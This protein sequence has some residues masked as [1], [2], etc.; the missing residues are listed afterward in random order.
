[1][2]IKNFV[3]IGV[4]SIDPFEKETVK[5]FGIQA[6]GMREI[7][8]YGIEKVMEMALEKVD[9]NK[10][11][12]IHCSFDIDSLDVLEAPSTGTPVRGGLS[13][14][15]GLYIVEE[16]EKTGRLDAIDLVEVN[17]TIGTPEDVTKTVD[18]AILVLK[19]AC[20]DTRWGNLPN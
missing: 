1:M 15:E 9:P 17:P 10:T 4:R 11:K 19:A 16:L 2:S 8:K 13:L 20:G 14:R 18:A 12:S 5:K 3:Y 7:Q 6:Y